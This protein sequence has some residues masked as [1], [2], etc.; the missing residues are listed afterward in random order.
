[1]ASGVPVITTT[2]TSLPEVAGNAALLLDPDDTAGLV[3]ALGQLLRDPAL[4]AEL[5]GRG[6]EHAR[7][8]SWEKAADITLATLR[9]A[10]HL[11]D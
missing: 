8:F 3:A 4:R 1:M 11:A 2:A 6:R 7:T 9:S 5:I 10:I